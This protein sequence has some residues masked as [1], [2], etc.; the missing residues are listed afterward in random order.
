MK[1][2]RIFLIWGFV[3]CVLVSTNHIAHFVSPLLNLSGL[4]GGTSGSSGTSS[5]PEDTGDDMT[6]MEFVLMMMEFQEYN[7]SEYDQED[8]PDWLYMPENIS[9]FAES[10]FPVFL[11]YDWENYNPDDF[12]NWLT[13]PDELPEDF[14][15]ADIINYIDED[16]YADVS[17][18]IETF[19]GS[20]EG[21]STGFSMDMIGTIIENSGINFMHILYSII[22]GGIGIILY[23]IQKSIKVEYIEMEEESE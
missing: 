9:D 8:F 3:I 16:F 5:I 14:Q 13:M 19:T 20:S 18:L 1:K 21:D 23:A 4:F 15:P 6:A 12:P 7:W 22:A 17:S 10:E 11:A 2:N